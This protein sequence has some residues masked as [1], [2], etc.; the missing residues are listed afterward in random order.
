MDRDW[1]IT[2]NLDQFL[3]HAGS[4]CVPAPPC[5]RFT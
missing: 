2:G 5:T 4:S 3:T 1:H